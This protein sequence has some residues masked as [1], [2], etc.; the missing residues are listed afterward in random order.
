MIKNIKK[1]VENNELTVEITCNVRRFAIYPEKV[2]TTS[3]I[4]D[5]IKEEYSIVSTKSTPR[6]SVGNSDRRKVKPSGKW[7]FVLS[8]EE[9]IAVVPMP[10]EKTEE[11][12]PKQTRKTRTKKKEDSPASGPSDIRSRM[13]SLSKK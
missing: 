6:Y 5:I 7:V 3:D 1:S 2:L 10:E 4:I 12:K 9:P 8:T 13:S 11:Q